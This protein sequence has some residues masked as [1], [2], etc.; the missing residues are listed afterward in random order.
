M[1]VVAV[2]GKVLASVDDEV[3][4]LAIEPI[5]I[6]CVLEQHFIVTNIG[7]HQIF[8]LLFYSF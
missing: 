5:A 7:A 3:E 2:I 4:A 1:I 8:Q 6:D